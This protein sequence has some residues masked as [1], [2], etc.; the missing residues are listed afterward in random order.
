MCIMFFSWDLPIIREVSANE[1]QPE[2]SPQ[3]RPV[4][5]HESSIS[6]YALPTVFEPP[7]ADESALG[8]SFT[9]YAIDK[10]PAGHG[11]STATIRRSLLKSADSARHR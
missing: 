2:S 5:R 7:S 4:T 6:S 1:A 8:K 3:A 10:P 9:E 11:A